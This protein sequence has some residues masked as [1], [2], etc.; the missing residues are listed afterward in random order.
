MVFHSFFNLQGHHSS[1]TH[2]LV[3]LATLATPSPPYFCISRYPPQ[4]YLLRLAS[5]VPSP[6]SSIM[7]LLHRLFV[8]TSLLLASSTLLLSSVSA[9][10]IVVHAPEP[11]NYQRNYPYCAVDVHAIKNFNLSVGAV[12]HSHP[13]TAHTTSRPSYAAAPATT[14]PPRRLFSLTPLFV[15]LR[16]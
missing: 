14:R 16:V 13:L 6:D 15:P 7:T 12:S 5:F 1:S 4:E 8:A 10:S 11:L 3:T 9:Q 2:H